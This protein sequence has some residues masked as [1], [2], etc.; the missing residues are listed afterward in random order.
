M[1]ERKKTMSSL[2]EEP[3]GSNTE[4]AIYKNDI[5]VE[6]NWHTACRNSFK[7]IDDLSKI[8][9]LTE[10]TKQLL[11][12][13]VKTF[14]MRIPLYYLS[15]IR[16]PSNA[17]DP[18]RKQCIPSVDEL[19]WQIHEKI[20]PLGEEKTSPIPCLVHRYPDRALLLATGRC[21]MYCRYCTR[22]RLWRSRIPEPTL[23][24]I[25]L[26]LT[27]VRENKDIREIIVSG[28]DPLTLSTER[29]DYILSSIANVNNIQAVRIGTRAPV[30]FPQRIDDNLCKVLSKYEN[31]WINT[32][33]NHPWEITPGATL[34]CK[35]LQRC[36]I[37]VSS[38]SV[39][40]KGVN[41]NLSVMLELC[42]KLQSIRVRPYYL[43]QCDPVVGASHFRTSIWKGI[44]LMEELRGHTGGMCIPTFVV[45]GTEGK[46]KIPLGP[47]YLLS[48]SPEGLILRNYKNEAFF[49]YNPKD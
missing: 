7:N 15:L 19:Q 8:F 38:Q 46:G 13:V 21:F 45:D 44:E 26:A 25:D 6:E 31:L 35:K 36:G 42:Q 12:Q 18:I 3:G 27:Y 11:K 22:K 33:F 39:L 9:P 5:I 30:V 17:S 10:E 29:L 37:P 2:E 4:P 47:N 40:L 43:Y 48:V 23:K 20:D 16:D 32:Q 41:D 14:H 49:Y 1:G 24:D 34:A 28:G